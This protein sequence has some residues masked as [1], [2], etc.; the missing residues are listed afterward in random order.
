M[1]RR[2]TAARRDCRRLKTEVPVL[3]ATLTAAEIGTCE[4]SVPMKEVW[5]GLYGRFG[6]GVIAD[7][8][9]ATIMSSTVRRTVMVWA[10][11]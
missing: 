8:H 3:D 11:S 2:L 6:I 5:T 10:F 9:V 4:P 1:W 7:A